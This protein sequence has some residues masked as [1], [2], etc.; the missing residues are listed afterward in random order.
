MDGRGR[1]RRP[2]VPYKLPALFGHSMARPENRLRGSSPETNDDF[3]PDHREFGFE[4]GP[5]CHRFQRAWFL[6]DPTLPAL[7]ELEV[8]DGVGNKDERSVDPGVLQCAIEQPARGSHEGSPQAIFFVSRLFPDKNDERR[9]WTFPGHRLCGVPVQVASTAALNSFP[10]HRE[11]LSR[12]NEFSGSLW[13]RMAQGWPASIIHPHRL[14][15]GVQ[16]G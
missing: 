6:V 10:Q 15:Y 1:S 2:G 11:S 3:G 7:F 5:A 9:S 13:F 4:P 16:S 8:F 12:R 14:N